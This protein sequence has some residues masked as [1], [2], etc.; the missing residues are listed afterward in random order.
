M[1]ENLDTQL[2]EPNIW[3][4]IKVPKKEKD[5]ERQRK[6]E[7][8]ERERVNSYFSYLMIVHFYIRRKP[9]IIWC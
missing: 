6:R 3:N 1:V 2:N 4:T 7:R 5:S 9:F 8:K